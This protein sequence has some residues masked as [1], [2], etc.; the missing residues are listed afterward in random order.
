[1]ALKYV[2]RVVARGPNEENDLWHL[3]RRLSELSERRG[4]D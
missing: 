1:M 3:V 4:Q 2:Q